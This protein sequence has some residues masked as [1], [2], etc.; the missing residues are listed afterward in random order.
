MVST[1]KKG[2]TMT[3][4]EKVELKERMNKL[5]YWCKLSMRMLI[6]NKGISQKKALIE[7]REKG[8]SLNK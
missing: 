7:L 2:S 6:D 8:D 1:T 4:K 3:N 5:D